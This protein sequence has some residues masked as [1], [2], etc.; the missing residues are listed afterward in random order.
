ME[1]STLNKTLVDL[2][3][4]I[5]NSPNQLDQNEK[6]A[7]LKQLKNLDKIT[8]FSNIVVTD[9][10][11]FLELT[12]QIEIKSEE[13]M[14]RENNPIIEE[15]YLKMDEN[16]D[17]DYTR[18]VRQR[19][20]KELSDEWNCEVT[21]EDL[22]KYDDAWLDEMS[23]GK[24]HKHYSVWGAQKHK[25][26]LK[27]ESLTLMALLHSF[28]GIKTYQFREKHRETFVEAHWR[29]TLTSLGL[30]DSETKRIFFGRIS[31]DEVFSYEGNIGF[32]TSAIL[33]D[34]L[35]FEEKRID[36]NYGKFEI[37]NVGVFGYKRYRIEPDNIEPKV[38]CLPIALI[39]D[40]ISPS[41]KTYKVGRSGTR[42]YDIEFKLR[43]FSTED[44]PQLQELVNIKE[45]LRRRYDI[46][47]IEEL[48]IYI[49]IQ[50]QK[51]ESDEQF[52]KRREDIVNELKTLTS[53]SP[54]D[55]GLK[56]ARVTTEEDPKMHADLTPQY[57][58]TPQGGMRASYG[59]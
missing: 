53:S 57:Q 54:R 15:F 19:R 58:Y 23:W 50:P 44:L 26:E 24:K 37:G 51:K 48:P 49:S 5:S 17:T 30:N 34:R 28:V 4:S 59:F 47:M 14:S 10:I 20:L 1:L 11:E 38:L 22:Q 41:Q 6:K 13:S 8:K 16:R 43:V 9:L 3:Q 18:E 52:M 45:T 56:I 33:S 42:N 7:L 27:P 32:M 46:E 21:E 29:R 39:S 25:L 40:I 36:G 2:M 12:D 35:P 55:I 31:D